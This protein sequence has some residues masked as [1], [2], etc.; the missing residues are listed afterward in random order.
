MSALPGFALVAALTIAVGAGGAT[1]GHATKAK[2]ISFNVVYSGS[3]SVVK[4]YH[5]R[6]RT[7]LANNCGLQERG[8]TIALSKLSWRTEWKGITRSKLSSNVYAKG[9]GLNGAVEDEEQEQ[10]YDPSSCPSGGSRTTIPP[11]TEACSD[12]APNLPSRARGK[13]AATTPPL[14]KAI[15]GYAV[16]KELRRMDKRGELKEYRRRMNSK[17]YQKK[18]II[19]MGYPIDVPVPKPKSGESSA[20][21]N[22]DFVIDMQAV[23]FAFKTTC[24]A[25]S[26]ALHDPNLTEQAL[27]HVMLMKIDKPDRHTKTARFSVHKSVPC[28]PMRNVPAN[29]VI[30]YTC[31]VRVDVRGSVTVSG[32]W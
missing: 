15:L 2:P 16:L 19:F 22:K 32:T 31:M 6:A 24:D 20:G 5:L 10:V 4:T 11:R 3:G 17:D 1:T 25:A 12:L 27:D 29:F 23:G 8:G 9:L 30:S 28:A 18:R 13:T 14:W 21:N 26:S 7:D